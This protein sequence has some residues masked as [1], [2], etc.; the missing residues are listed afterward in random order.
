MKYFHLAVG[1]WARKH[2]P[3]W[4]KTYL[5]YDITHKKTEVQNPNFFSLQA[6][7]LTESVGGLNSIPAQSELHCC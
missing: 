1:P 2:V 5:T 3:K 4:R 7:R 6:W